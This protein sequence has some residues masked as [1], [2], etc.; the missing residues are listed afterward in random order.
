MIP[1]ANDDV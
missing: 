1:K